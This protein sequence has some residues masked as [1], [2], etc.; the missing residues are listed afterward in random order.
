MPESSARPARSSVIAAM[1]RQM[2]CL[3]PERRSAVQRQTSPRQRDNGQ[4]TA[5]GED[6]DDDTSSISSR[7][8]Q[9]PVHPHTPFPHTPTH[10]PKHT[11]TEQLS[12]K[13]TLCSAQDCD[14]PSALSGQSPSAASS[15]RPRPQATPP[16]RQRRSERE[17]PS[18]S[19]ASQETQRAWEDL[20]HSVFRE[21]SQVS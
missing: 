15:P 3:T 1:A 5:D 13:H 21:L 17:H 2:R 11:Q 10:D 19:P 16:H 18:S 12:P 20:S 6:E 4:R 7:D 9:E 8:R 14:H